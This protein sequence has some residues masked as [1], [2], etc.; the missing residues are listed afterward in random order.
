MEPCL[1]E[2]QEIRSMLPNWACKLTMGPSNKIIFL[3]KLRLTPLNKATIRR[4][5]SKFSQSFSYTSNITTKTLCSFLLQYIHCMIF[6]I[7]KYYLIIIQTEIAELETKLEDRRFGND[8]QRQE[9]MREKKE[10]EEQVRP[11][12]QLGYCHLRQKPVIAWG[13]FRTHQNLFI[14]QSNWQQLFPFQ[15]ADSK[16]FLIDTFLVFIPE[17]IKIFGKSCNI[18]SSELCGVLG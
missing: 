1:V 16:Q 3:R 14:S 18:G 10:K 4:N 9:V 8:R 15:V 17:E 2:S 12:F 13:C 11:R 5:Y 6:L 7:L